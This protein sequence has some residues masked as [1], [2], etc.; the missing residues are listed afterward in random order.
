MLR[1]AHMT[2][3]THIYARSHTRTHKALFTSRGAGWTSRSHPLPL[4][5][6]IHCAPF[7]LIA[8]GVPL[9]GEQK[10]ER[11]ASVGSALRL[12]SQLPAC[13]LASL[14]ACLPACMPACKRALPHKFPATHQPT[15]PPSH[16]P[17]LYEYLSPSNW[18]LGLDCRFSFSSSS[19]A[20]S[21]HV[22]AS[23]SW[24]VNPLR[25]CRQR[26]NGVSSRR[27]L[28]RANLGKEEALCLF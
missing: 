9:H 11:T 27:R 17:T 15:D 24:A 4:H 28:L 10:L 25:S 1:S 19:V 14:P 18:I 3:C 21:T 22:P 16:S 5:N 2:T 23:T 20:T 13:L 7:Q 26:I 6:E 12:A 8:Q